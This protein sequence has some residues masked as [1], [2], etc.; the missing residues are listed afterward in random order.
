[1]ID[2]DPSRI[3]L[4][5]PVESGLVGDTANVLRA[6]LPRLNY[7]DDRAFLEKAQAGMKEWNALLGERGTRCD[8]PMKPEVVAYELNRIVPDDAIVATDSG[9]V[10][11]WIARHL[12]IRNT[13]MFSCSG[14]LASMACGLPY[15]IAAAIAFPQRPVI[16]FIGDG[17]L[18]MLLGEL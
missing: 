11:T 17:G 16:A 1:Q 13:M 4:R 18:A 10:T 5:Y 8:S 7:R 15:A 6:L 2:L 9:T 14:N 12:A 3:G